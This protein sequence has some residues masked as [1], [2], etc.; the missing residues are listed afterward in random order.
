MTPADA[1]AAELFA[2]YWNAAFPDPQCLGHYPALLAT[3]MEPDI[4]PGDLARICRPIDWFGFNHYSP[5]YAAADPALPLGF[6][7]GAAPADIPRTPIDWPIAPD[8]IRDG[9]R[10]VYAR[11]HL[12]IYVT[13]NGFGAY[14]SLDAVGG[15]VDEDRIGF[16]NDYI[17]AVNE[18]IAAGTD[19]RGYFVW[20]LLDNF[21]WGQ[22]YA[23]RFGLVYMDYPTQKRIPK[24]SFRWYADRIRAARGS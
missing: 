19:V 7:F 8:A 2:A 15:V 9:L 1:A 16:L 14:D 21:E 5:L 18:A 6:G 20:S 13:E 4:Q 12:P 10:A 3:V 24:A 17:H 22:G 11:Y 23:V